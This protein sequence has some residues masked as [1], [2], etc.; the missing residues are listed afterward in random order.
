MLSQSMESVPRTR[1][2]KKAVSVLIVIAQRHSEGFPGPG[3]NTW[4]A[5]ISARPGEADETQAS[6]SPTAP[7]EPPPACAAEPGLTELRV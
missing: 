2:P 7:R 4:N 5:V 1:L 6:L 3:A